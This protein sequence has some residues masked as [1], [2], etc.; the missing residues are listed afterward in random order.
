MSAPDSIQIGPSHWE[1]LAPPPSKGGHASWPQGYGGPI[2]ASMA[3]GARDRMIRAGLRASR[4]E[5]SDDQSYAAPHSGS[6]GSSPTVPPSEIDARI[7]RAL[8]CDRSG[9]TRGGEADFAHISSTLPPSSTRD[10]S[11]EREPAR[12]VSQPGLVGRIQGPLPTPRRGGGWVPRTDARS[13]ASPQS[14]G[15]A[16]LGRL[17]GE[18]EGAGRGAPTDLLSLMSVG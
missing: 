15:L 9:N 6:D 13:W 3:C 1:K 16:A 4:G 12:G 8:A 18:A 5:R 14:C 2:A 7:T 10:L 17:P 11:L